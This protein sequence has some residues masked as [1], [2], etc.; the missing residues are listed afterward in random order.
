MFLKMLE[1]EYEASS[2]TGWSLSDRFFRGISPNNPTK[3]FNVLSKYKMD[4]A[5]G[6]VIGTCD[7]IRPINDSAYYP[8]CLLGM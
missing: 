2:Y 3:N 1:K 5:L 4:S 7:K 6:L 8:A